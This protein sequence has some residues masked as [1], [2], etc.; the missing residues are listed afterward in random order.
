[1]S[2]TSM[3]IHKNYKRL[4]QWMQGRNAVRQAFSPLFSTVL[5]TT[6]LSS[7]PV[8]AQERYG[9][10]VNSDSP[11]M[12]EVVQQVQPGAIIRNYR[13]RRVIEAGI[14]FRQDEA[15]RLVKDLEL[16]GIA[17]KI[18]DFEDEEEFLGPV[19]AFAPVLPLPTEEEKP[20][21]TNAPPIFV[22]PQ[23]SLGLHI[24]V[25]SAGDAVLPDVQRVSPYAKMQQ[26][27]GKLL[28]QAG[29]FVNLFNAQQLVRELAVY[30]VPADIIMSL[31]ELQAWVAIQPE[32]PVTATSTIPEDSSDYGLARSKSYFVIIPGQ[33][34]ELTAIAEDVIILGAPQN[35]VK[36]QDLAASPFVAVG[37]FANQT[38]AKEWEDYFIDSGLPGAQVYFGK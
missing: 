14:Y 11:F 29:S 37:P 26:Y 13:H 19:S 9:V 8:R 2:I 6:V 38:L 3:I 12:L 10:Y 36:I 34:T 4:R 35:S 18:T 1:M 20:I 24:V 32:I 7:L 15:E 22:F 33:Q 30:G 31:E 25:V 27:Q 28:I 5:L 23:E 16:R 21:E 17:A